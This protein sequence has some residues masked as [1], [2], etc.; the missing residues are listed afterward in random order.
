M[1]LF[2]HIVEIFHLTDFDRSAVLLMVAFDRR[3][4]RR[5]P[6]DGDLFGDPVTADRLRQQAQRGFSSSVLREEKVNG[7]PGLVH[8]A[9]Q[10]PPLAFHPDR[11]F[12]HPPAVPDRTLAAMKRLCQLRTVLHDPALD[13]R[14]VDWHPALLHP[15][16]HMP[17]TQGVGHIPAH[18]H[19]N[20]ILREMGSLEAH[21]HRLSPSLATTDH[22]GRS[23]RKSPPMK[24]CDRTGSRPNTD[25][26]MSPLWSIIDIQGPDTSR[27]TVEPR[28]IPHDRRETHANLSP[29]TRGIA[30]SKLVTR[31]ASGT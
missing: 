21:R 11:G 5:A 7:L 8:R 29:A 10:I 28:A 4:I 13:G 25:D 19:A 22:G 30:S 27:Q 1:I 17:I 12:I 3:F 16:F 6:I 15:F 20:D 23:Y 31:D 2:D 14:V 9:R 26:L 18:P 24:T